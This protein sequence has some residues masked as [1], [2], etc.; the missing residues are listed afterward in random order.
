MQI[1]QEPIQVC[2]RI[3]VI[4][5][6]LYPLP[7]LPA[8]KL[9]SSFKTKGEARSCTSTFAWKLFPKQESCSIFPKPTRH[10]AAFPLQ[11]PEWR[12]CTFHWTR[13]FELRFCFFLG[14][15]NPFAHAPLIFAKPSDQN[16]RTKVNCNPLFICNMSHS[17]NT[18]LC[19]V[20]HQILSQDGQCSLNKQIFNILFQ[21]HYSACGSRPHLPHTTPNLLGRHHC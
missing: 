7:A 6:K 8:V 5:S 20:F 4:I 14:S 19:L 12:S 21:C 13:I 18:G 9:L 2:A 17:L 11:S 10:E 16:I 15:G 3:Q 1:L